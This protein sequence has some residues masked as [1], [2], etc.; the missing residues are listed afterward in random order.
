VRLTP[1]DLDTPPAVL[2][3]ALRAADIVFHLAGVNRPLDEEE[4]HEGNAE[5]TRHVCQRLAAA[6]RKAA[7]VIASSIQADLDNPHGRSERAAEEFV[8]DNPTLFALAAC[9]QA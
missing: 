7:L 9:V 5:L 4:F 1:C 6:G 2:D 8:R 3:A